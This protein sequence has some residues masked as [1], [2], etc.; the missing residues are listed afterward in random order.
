[1]AVRPSHSLH[2][3]AICACFE[4]TRRS[5][6]RSQGTTLRLLQ[7]APWQRPGISCSLCNAGDQTL[8]LRLGISAKRSRT[9]TP[10]QP[11]PHCAR[12]TPRD[13]ER[14]DFPKHFRLFPRCRHIPSL[15]D[16]A[17]VA[18]S[19]PCRWPIEEAH[20]VQRRRSA[21]GASA[22]QS[23]HNSLPALRGHCM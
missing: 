16:E 12:T 22:V 6:V 8:R 5:P 17:I 10:F 7:L 19:I 15:T 2:M 11:L 1:M 23:L 21:V 20:V 4:L 3:S 13:V 18:N 14:E 9:K